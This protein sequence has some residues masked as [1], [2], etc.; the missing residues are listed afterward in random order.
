MLIQIFSLPLLITQ[1]SPSDHD[2]TYHEQSDSVIPYIKERT[3]FQIDE[4]HGICIVTH[5][6]EVCDDLCP[7]RHGGDRCKYAAYEHEYH[8]EEPCD[9]HGL[10]GV[11]T[12][13]GYE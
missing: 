9:E 12:V 6:I 8:H 2:S 13:V 10:L 1:Y 7:F 5:R 11:V 3:A 4:P